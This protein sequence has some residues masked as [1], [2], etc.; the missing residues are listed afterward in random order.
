[1][2]DK[3]RRWKYIL[4]TSAFY[5]LI[6]LAVLYFFTFRNG[7][8]YRGAVMFLFAVCALG[9]FLLGRSLNREHH[10]DEQAQEDEKRLAKLKHDTL[11]LAMEHGGVLTVT[12]VAADLEVTLADAERILT[13]LEDG[14]RVVSTVTE[15]GVIVYEFKEV[16]HRQRRMD[17]SGPRQ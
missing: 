12:D 15:D 11:Q 2:T 3:T 4:K 5:F 9:A 6:F 8:P 17:A 7:T 1:M 13:S 14:V 10:E 16:I